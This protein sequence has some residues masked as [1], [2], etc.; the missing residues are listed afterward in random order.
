MK[1]EPTRKQKNEVVLLEQG[2]FHQKILRPSTVSQSQCCRNDRVFLKNPW[3]Y[4][5]IL[6]ENWG[7]VAAQNIVFA[8]IPEFDA[9]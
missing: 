8:S 9:S 2:H 6:R 7:G 1:S 4:N 3:N 5:A